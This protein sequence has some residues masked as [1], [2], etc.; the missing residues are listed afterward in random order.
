MLSAVL[1]AFIGGPVAMQLLEAGHDL[2]CVHAPLD[3][4]A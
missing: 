1:A 3:D 4:L 2:T